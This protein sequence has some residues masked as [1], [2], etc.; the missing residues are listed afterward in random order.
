MSQSPSRPMM[1]LSSR[2][3]AANL[4]DA[5]DEAVDLLVVEAEALEH[6]PRRLFGVLGDG[7]VRERWAP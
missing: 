6:V 4:V 2:A 7:E 5:I 3:V 1:S